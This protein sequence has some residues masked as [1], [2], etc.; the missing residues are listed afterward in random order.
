MRNIVKWLSQ[1][2]LLIAAFL[3]GTYSLIDFLGLEVSANQLR[4]FGWTLHGDKQ[5]IEFHLRLYCS[6]LALALVV[7]MDILDIYLPARKM[8]DTRKN[9]MG[10]KGDLFKE[11]IKSKDLRI[12]IWY[13]RRPWYWPLWKTF[14]LDWKTGFAAPIDKDL[15]V[16]LAPWQGVSG[17]AFRSREP[18]ILPSTI[19][20]NSLNWP[21]KWLLMNEHRMAHWQLEKVAAV[22]GLISIPMLVVRENKPDKA[23]GVINVDSVTEAGAKYIAENSLDLGAFFLDQGKALALLDF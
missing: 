1:L 22:T 3:S 20:I 15:K 6:V 14:K 5:H 2:L 17:L 10:L 16:R 13:L 12:S 21:E 23:V 9:Y 8:K 4:F 7:V 11:K 19:S 18:K